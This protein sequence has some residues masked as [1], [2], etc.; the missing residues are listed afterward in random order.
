[1][2]SFPGQIRIAQRADLVLAALKILQSKYDDIWLVNCWYNLWPAST[3][4]MRYSRHIQFDFREG[5]SWRDMMRRTYLE[6]GL[7]ADRI[8]TQELV[9]HEAQRALFAETDIGVFPNRCEGGTNLV[10]MEYMA[11]AKPVIA[12]NASGHTD[13]LTEQNA[14]RLNTL[15]N[16]NV[17]DASGRLIGRWQE[18]SVDE[19]VAHIEFAYLHRD[20][21]AEIGRTAGEDLKHWTW[22]KTAERLR[23]LIGL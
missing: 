23:L 2:Y 20:A 22:D 17:N 12:T 1:M 16:F 14:L 3:Q 4:L 8:I 11:C 19:L 13:I 21:I 15:S 7:D 9:P 6:N 10:M 18:P 5:E